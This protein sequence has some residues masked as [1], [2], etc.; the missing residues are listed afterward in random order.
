MIGLFGGT[1]DPVHY[2]HLRCALELQEALRFAEFHLVPCRIPPHR[3]VPHASAEQRLEM[4]NA[5]LD[6]TVGLSIDSR[7]L[8]RPGPSYS[9]D[10]LREVRAEIGATPLCLIIGMDAFNGLDRWHRWEELIDLA[11]IVVAHRPGW[12]PPEQGPVADLLH[13]QGVVDVQ[14]LR[15]QPAGCVLPWTVTGLDI[16]A[17]AIRAMV[18]AGR[19]PRYLL[20]DAVLEIIAREHLYAAPGVA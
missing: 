5:A 13:R 9:V 18:A 6:G 15:M 20:P 2:G 17:S 7:E 11:H 19:N 1:F 12:T 14:P 3:G 10:T 4:L 8:A 16:S